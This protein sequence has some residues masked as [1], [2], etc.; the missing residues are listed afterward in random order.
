MAFWILIAVMTAASLLF[1]LMPLMRDGGSRQRRRAES[2]LRA[3]RDAGL[4][5]S[6]EF[7]RKLAA[8]DQR[9][10]PSQPPARGAAAGLSL[11]LP[12]AAAA[13]YFHLGEPR[14]LDPDARAPGVARMAAQG[15]SEAADAPDMEQAVQGLAQRLREDPDNLD[16]WLLL[17]RAYKAME[18]FEPALEALTQAY[19]LAPD[20]PDVMIEY[21]E[22][23]ALAAPRR[24]IEGENLA[25]IE[26]AVELQPDHQRGIWLLGVAAMQG[27]RPK[28]A[29]DRWETLRQLISS[30][31]S[32]VQALDEQIEAARQA[33]GLPPARVST[34]IV[35]SAEGQS[36]TPAE[37]ASPAGSD[38]AAGGPRL[39]VIVDIAPALRERLSASDV[40]FV[41]ARP[42]QGSRMPLAIQRLPAANLPVTVTLDDSQSMMPALKLSTMPEVVV[43]ARVSSSG[44]AIP[45]P[46]DFEGLSAPLPNT[47]SEPIRLTIDQV[48]E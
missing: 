37:P 7:A 2:T 35:E 8:L 4:L 43:G 47:T 1:V 10:A 45:Q 21:A 17:G 16:G 29:V 28:D 34:A 25:L 32:A 39:T 18:R 44:Q 9:G 41:F 42:A 6:E 48:V 12:F 36:A 5:D 11:L 24:R 40:L 46:G 14:A 22:G 20:N 15:G 19:R 30:D 31:L 26:Q 3:A 27:G 23:K 33:A 13:L 38:D